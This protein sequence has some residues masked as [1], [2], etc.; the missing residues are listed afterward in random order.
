MRSGFGGRAGIRDG[1]CDGG[2]RSGFGVR[3]GDLR[4]FLRCGDTMLLD[5]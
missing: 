2:E 1:D 4:K 3:V 5:K